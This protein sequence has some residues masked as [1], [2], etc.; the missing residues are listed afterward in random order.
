MLFKTLQP[1]RA[2]SVFVAVLGVASV[3]AILNAERFLIDPH[4]SE[5]VHIARFKWLLLA[6]GVAGMIA[7]ITGAVQLSTRIRRCRVKL[8]RVTGRIYVVTVAAASLIALYINAKFEPWPLNFEVAVQAT[9]W[10]SATTVGYIAARYRQMVL[11]R[12]WM[13]R[14][15]A[16]TLIFIASRLPIY[17]NFNATELSTMLWYLIVGALILPDLLETTVQLARSRQVSQ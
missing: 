9:L 5:W 7:L 4:D 3:V 10:L 6:H 12:Q 17:P 13:V 1:V 16:I 8:H 11:H 15:Y 14:S 2:R